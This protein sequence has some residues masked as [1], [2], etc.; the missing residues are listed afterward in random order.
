MSKSTKRKVP[1]YERWLRKAVKDS[2]WF[3]GDDSGD[4]CSVFPGYIMS[5]LN[6]KEALEKE[7][8]RLKAKVEELEFAA[9]GD[10]L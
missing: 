6:D 10:D 1:E 8:E 2:H 9:Q 4:M 3:P 7:V 5:L